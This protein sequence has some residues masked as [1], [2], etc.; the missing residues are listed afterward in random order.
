MAPLPRTAVRPPPPGVHWHIAQRQHRTLLPPQGAS[1]RTD[2]DRFI[3]AFNRSHS[4]T[5]LLQDATTYSQD[6]TGGISRGQPHTTTKHR[7]TQSSQWYQS[8]RP[9]TVHWPDMTG[10]SRSSRQG[11]DAHKQMVAATSRGT[12]RPRLHTAFFMTVEAPVDSW[13]GLPT[14]TLNPVYIQNQ[15]NREG[16]DSKKSS[17][18]TRTIVLTKGYI[19]TLLIVQHSLTTW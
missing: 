3:G 4:V 5:T 12:R 17:G 16:V 6:A 8:D 11:N 2:K 9:I 1:P 19:T 10:R 13:R 7:H 18:S 14:G 15:L